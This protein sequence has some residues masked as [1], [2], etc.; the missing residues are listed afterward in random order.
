MNRE[1][2]EA[3]KEALEAPAPRKKNE[4]LRGLQAPRVSNLE[5]VCIQAGYIRKW[6]WCISALAFLVVLIGSE[7]LKKDML[8][9]ISAF[10]PLLALSVITESGRSFTYGMA[11]LELSARFSLKSIVLARLGILGAANLCLAWLLIFLANGNSRATVLQA[12]VY[13][14]CPYLLTAFCGLWVTRKVRG[15]EAVYLCIGIAAFVSA[16]NYTAFHAFFTLYEE[17]QFI[18]WVAALA[19]LAAGTAKEFYQTIRQTEELAWNL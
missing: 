12:A 13:I 2:K 1:V 5:F 14:L 7:Y 15:K 4:F 3:L 17:R 8:W 6:I 9:C 18:G 16:G 10:M 19:L 11:E